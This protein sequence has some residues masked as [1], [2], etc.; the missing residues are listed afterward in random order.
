MNGS[1]SG[2]KQRGCRTDS[3]PHGDGSSR[4]ARTGRAGGPSRALEVRP[5]GWGGG[6]GRYLGRH[7]PAAGRPEQ[8]P[9]AAQPPGVRPS[10]ARGR[11]VTFAPG[12][13]PEGSRGASTSWAGDPRLGGGLVGLGGGLPSPPPLP[14]GAG[15]PR[16]GWEAPGAAAAPRPS[17]R[18]GSG[19]AAGCQAS[20]TRS[21]P[22]TSCRAERRGRPAGGCGPGWRRGLAGRCFRGSGPLPRPPPLGA[23][24]PLPP[25]VPR[26]LPAPVAMATA[27]PGLR[28]AGPGWCFPPSFAVPFSSFFFFFLLLLSL[29]VRL[30]GR[31]G[32]TE[33]VLAS[34][35]E[36]TSPRNGGRWRREG[37]DVEKGEHRG[38]SWSVWE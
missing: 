14:G 1:A 26:F 13:A 25:R 29:R 3:I 31:R 27:L 20:G 37:S 5:G 18:S 24:L 38:F 2:Q 15:A 28:A 7:T 36:G 22:V 12:S 8:P 17:R 34:S 6:R 23:L 16:A 4:K 35:G 33:R 21:G 10:P 11:R 9:R 19:P 32:E 30:R